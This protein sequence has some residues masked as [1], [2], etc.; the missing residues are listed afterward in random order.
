[1]HGLKKWFAAATKKD[2]GFPQ[3]QLLPHMS[4]ISRFIFV[5]AAESAYPQSESERII[6]RL[7]RCSSIH[8]DFRNLILDY[9]LKGHMVRP[10]PIVLMHYINIQCT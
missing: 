2:F 4:A 5:V 8:T 3:L 7:N 9:I 1:M 6:P 10:Y